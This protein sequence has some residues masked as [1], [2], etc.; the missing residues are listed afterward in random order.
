[1]EGVGQRD[2]NILGSFHPTKQRV[3]K[4][5]SIYTYCKLHRGNVDVSHGGFTVKCRVDELT[6]RSV[7]SS[8]SAVLLCKY[9]YGMISLKLINID[10]GIYGL[11][12]LTM[13]NVYTCKS[14][15]AKMFP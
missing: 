9:I 5:L 14:E 1:M 8:S 6:H 13:Y 7:W 15:S 4:G 12:A 3:N 10:G 2:S 11:A